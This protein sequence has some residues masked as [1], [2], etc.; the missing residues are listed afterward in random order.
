VVAGVVKEQFVELQVVRA[1]VLLVNLQALVQQHNLVK[2]LASQE[3]PI[4]VNLADQHLP[5]LVKLVLAGAE[6]LLM[7]QVDQMLAKAAMDT[8]GL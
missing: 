4:L 3:I 6:P 8:L 7:W 5:T 2:I 1:V